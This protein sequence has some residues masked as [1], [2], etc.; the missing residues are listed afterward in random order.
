MFHKFYSLQQKM[1]NHLICFRHRLINLGWAD[2]DWLLAIY[3]QNNF[4]QI[5]NSGITVYNFSHAF[6]EVIRKAID[7]L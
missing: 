2:F 7:F 6:R 4:D 3:N 1:I 5:F